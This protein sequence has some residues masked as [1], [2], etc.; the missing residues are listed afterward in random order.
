MCE[1]NPYENYELIEEYCRQCCEG[2]PPDEEC[3]GCEC[4]YYCVEESAE[5]DDTYAELYHEYDEECDEEYEDEGS[6]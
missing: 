4:E 1:E 6:W 3:P 5:Y 2:C